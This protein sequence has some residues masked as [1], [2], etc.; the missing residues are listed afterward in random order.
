[1][2]ENVEKNLSEEL[3]R[4]EESSGNSFDAP[5]SPGNLGRSEAAKAADTRTEWAGIPGWK[6]IPVENLPSQ[7]MF[8]PIG[9]K[10]YIRAAEVAEVRQFSTIDE[11][12]PLD[13]D[14]KLNM[15]MEK[16]L[17]IEYPERIALWKDLKEEDRFYLIFAI[18]ELTFEEGEN[19]LYVNMRCGMTCKGDGTYQ[20]KVDMTKENFQYYNIDPVL[21][22]YYSEKERCFVISD[23]KVGTL[24]IYV[25]SL[26][27]TTFIK[28]FV[29][30]RLQQGDYYDKP[31]L[32]V[33]PFLFEDWRGLNDDKYKKMQ[34]DSVG[35]SHFK[36][37]LLIRAIEMIRFGVKMQITRQCN[38]CG[39]EV[40]API[41]F[42][43]G[44]KSLLVVSNP[45][46]QLSGR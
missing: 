39:A 13:M 4:L 3:R 10:M 45:F 32:K 29:R 27:I 30:E 16:C 46:E 5:M 43:G 7:G 28:N 9:T 2:E 11:N 12:D 8:Y 17:K 40:G 21:M 1:M 42:P 38:K 23:P 6:P 41:T 18:R 33:A 14:D 37:S 31:F 25:P 44:V 20:E 24:K 34:I 22:R 35:W 19:K 36:W 26:G 15:L